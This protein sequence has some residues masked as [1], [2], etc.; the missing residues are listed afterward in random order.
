M[1]ST[2]P[3]EVDLSSV[4]FRE[5]KVMKQEK[6]LFCSFPF[7]TFTRPEIKAERVDRE[8]NLIIGPV[9]LLS[10]GGTGIQNR[11]YNVH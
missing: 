3:R 10:H 4:R 2:P 7:L 8:R 11:R 6:E 1:E 9:S 5:V